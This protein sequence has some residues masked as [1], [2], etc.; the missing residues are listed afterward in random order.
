MFTNKHMF[1]RHKS[2]EDCEYLLLDPIKPLKKKIKLENYVTAENG[3]KLYIC[4]KCPLKFT[5]LK[6]LK[7]HRKEHAPK[8]FIEDHTYYFDEVQEIYICN[9]CSAEFKDKDETEKHTKAHGE[10]FGCS[11]CEEKFQ[12]LFQLGNHLKVNYK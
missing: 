7:E 4:K 10:N 2:K 8:E 11:L 12:T 3:E 5:M 6:L 1:Q 9:T